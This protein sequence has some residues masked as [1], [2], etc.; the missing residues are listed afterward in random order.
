[1]KYF[2][3]PAIGF[4]AGAALPGS[5]EVTA[6]QFKDGSASQR[7][8]ELA[9]TPLEKLAVRKIKAIRA[10]RDR[11]RDGGIVVSGV[12]FDTDAAAVTMYHATM[13]T[14]AM[15]PNWSTPNWKAG[16]DPATGLG[17]YVAMDAAK[18]QAIWLA[19]VSHIDACHAW[20]KAREAEVAAAV[21]AGNKA[22]LEAVSVV[23]SV[24]PMP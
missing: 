6:Q 20:Q 23:C 8:A 5:V 11:V 4:H 19:G 13:T 12:R 2:N 1:M 24:E 17:T 22:A 9:A 10:E 16:T 18:L 3:H 21:S 15:V 7:S 14:A